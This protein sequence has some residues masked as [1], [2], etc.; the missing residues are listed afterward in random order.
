M[1][2]RTLDPDGRDRLALRFVPLQSIP[3]PAGPIATMDA[4]EGHLLEWIGSPTA[5]AVVRWTGSRGLQIAMPPPPGGVPPMLHRVRT[6]AWAYLEGSPG[7]PVFPF[8]L[9]QQR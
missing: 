6:L 3:I 7:E 1:A 5:Y 2:E 9:E 8:V 4:L